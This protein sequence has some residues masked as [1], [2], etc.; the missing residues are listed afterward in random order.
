MVDQ[1]RSLR[2]D[3]L[4]TLRLLVDIALRA[5]SPGVNDPTT[6]V[7]SLDTIESV[8]RT[9]AP[10]P[11][12]PIALTRGRGRV[13]LR[14]PTW[15]DIVDLALMEVLAAGI[16]APQVTR[17][18]MALLDD[19]LADVPPERRPPLQ[20]YRALLVEGVATSF[21]PDART[22]ALIADRQ[23]IGGSRAP[24]TVEVPVG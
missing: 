24:R 14:R 1:E 4:Y 23:G 18:L 3:P 19:L 2:L 16:G 8:L 11:V 20:R 13:V 15:A 17:R 22:I 21:P 6:A 7:R 5:L 10:A 9:V 12:G